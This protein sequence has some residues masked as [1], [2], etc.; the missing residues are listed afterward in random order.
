MKRASYIFGI[1]VLILTGCGASKKNIATLHETYLG[2]SM[3]IDAVDIHL[4]KPA[5]WKRW[6]ADFVVI[7][8]TLPSKTFE[9][10]AS[11]PPQGY[12]SWKKLGELFVP[13]HLF[14][15]AQMPK[16]LMSEKEERGTY[17]SIIIDPPS[18]KVITIHYVD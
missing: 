14:T 2:I 16:A 11:D 8:Y 1:T 10:F 4:D 13:G 5:F 18:K 7:E 17:S 12:S 15:S 6:K 3:P 9:K